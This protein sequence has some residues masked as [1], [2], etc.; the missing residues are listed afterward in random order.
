MLEFRSSNTAHRPVIEALD[1]IVR[2]AGASGQ[3]YSAG[4][5]RRPQGRGSTRTGTTCW[6]S[7]DSRGPQADHAL[8]LRG[9][10]A[11][12]V[13]RP[14]AL[15]G[16]LGASAPTNG[17]TPTK[18]SPP[19]LRPTAPS[20]TTSCT[21]ARSRGVHRRAA[22]R[23]ARRARRAQRRAAR[24]GLAEDRQPKSGAIRLTPLR[25]SPRRPTCAVS[26]RRSKTAGEQ[27]PLI[28]MV[29]EAALRTGMLA[30]LTPS[31]P[32]RRSSATLCGSG[33]CSR[34]RLRHQHRHRS[35]RPRA[36]N[37]HSEADIR[38]VARRYFTIEGARA[39]AIQLAN[40]TFAARQTPDLGREHHHRGL[41]LHPF[42]VAT[43]RT[44]SPSGTP[45][46]AAGAC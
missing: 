4:R 23:D 29:K 22:R 15:Q 40:A 10:R 25:R 31:G 21:A 19:T 37:G 43:T 41:R 18:I 38:Y 17:E 2:H 26:R 24:P 6:C 14:A 1:L 42:P 46:T 39:V 44:C 33:C 3:Y 45:A 32:G 8:R 16:D 9:V 12:S 28:D 20:T 11:P 27:V 36:S 34:L 35:R 30:Q 13:A 5:D 7:I